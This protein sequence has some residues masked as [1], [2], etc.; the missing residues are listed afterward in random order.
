MNIPQKAHKSILLDLLPNE[1][2]IYD[3]DMKPNRLPVM[4]MQTAFHVSGAGTFYQQKD[5]D[6]E[7]LPDS[8]GFS[9]D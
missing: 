2:I 4:L 8:K 3:Y 1:R 9:Q 6:E 5:V 7:K